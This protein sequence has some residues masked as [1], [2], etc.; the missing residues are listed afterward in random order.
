[1]IKFAKRFIAITV[2]LALTITTSGAFAKEG[3]GLKKKEIEE[4]KQKVMRIAE[5]SD[6]LFGEG[7]SFHNLDQG[8]TGD[9]SVQWGS[10]GINKTHQYLAARGLTIL[11]NDKGSSVANNYYT[12]GAASIIME[13][14]DMPDVDE[15]Q[16]V[17]AAHFYNPYTGLNFIAQTNPTAKTKFIDHYNNAVSNY[18]SNPTYAYQELGR[19]IHFLSDLNEPHHAANAIAGVTNHIEFEG[20]VDAYRYTYNVNNSSWYTYV[21]TSTLDGISN[22][23]A[24]HAYGYLEWAT[25]VTNQAA[26]FHVAANGTLPFAQQFVAALL[27][28]FLDD[29][30]VV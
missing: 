7:V 22:Y 24:Y 5:G 8:N 17:F 23:C 1:M 18:S 20:W 3:T 6:E 19:A 9:V 4:L 13:Y 15:N 21:S 16:D 30:G 28:R 29:V 25:A 12:T 14:A 10:G 11:Q 27:Y 26:N 2:T